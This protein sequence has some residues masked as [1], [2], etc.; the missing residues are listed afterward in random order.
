MTVA[1]ST[2]DYLIYSRQKI[3]AISTVIAII[4]NFDNH[5]LIIVI[6][7]SKISVRLDLFLVFPLFDN[8]NHNAYDH[9]LI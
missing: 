8:H 6:H 3:T 5:N 9:L 4:N 7:K 1:G 2:V